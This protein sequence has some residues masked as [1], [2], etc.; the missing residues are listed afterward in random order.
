MSALE[1]FDRDRERAKGMRI[2]AREFRDL[3]Q[4]AT[5]GLGMSHGTKRIPDRVADRIAVAYLEWAE[6]ADAAAADL[7]A[8]LEARLKG[9][10]DE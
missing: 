9:E 7:E 5:C 10:G 1:R 4:L 3:H 6:E 8:S 2:E